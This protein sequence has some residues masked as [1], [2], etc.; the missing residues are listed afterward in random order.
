[1]GEAPAAAAAGAAEAAASTCLEPPVDFHSAV[2]AAAAAAAAAELW[3]AAE[4]G[5]DASLSDAESSAAAASSGCDASLSLSSDEASILN[6]FRVFTTAGAR[7]LEAEGASEAP[8]LEEGVVV[9]GDVDWGAAE[10]AAAGAS[11]CLTLPPS[12]NLDL[13]T[14]M[15]SRSSLIE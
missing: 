5:A 4:A 6:E 8:F 11:D 3:A 15:A 14:A 1:M 13:S 12:D 7:D 10:A 9:P 2:G